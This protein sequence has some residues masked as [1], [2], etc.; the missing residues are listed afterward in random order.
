M[1]QM[2]GGGF[3]CSC[4]GGVGHRAGCT[5]R[6]PSPSPAAPCHGGQGDALHT[7]EINSETPPCAHPLGVPTGGQWG[8]G[9]MPASCTALCSAQGCSGPWV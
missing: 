9:G 4:V 3:W 5:R 1:P 8:L 6:P 7:Q 2:W